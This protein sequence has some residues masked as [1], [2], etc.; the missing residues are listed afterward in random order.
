MQTFTYISVN[1]GDSRGHFLRK[2]PSDPLLISDGVHGRLQAGSL[3]EDSATSHVFQPNIGYRCCWD[4]TTRRPSMV[5]HSTSFSSVLKLTSDQ[6]MFEHI[7]LV[8]LLPTAINH[9][10]ALL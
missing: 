2:L 6:R 9:I 10:D 8:L 1:Q 5:M 3:H 7:P 4:C